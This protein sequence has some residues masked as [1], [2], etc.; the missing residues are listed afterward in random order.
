[1][2]TEILIKADP[3]HIFKHKVE[4]P[5]PAKGLLQ[6][7]N[8]VLLQGPEHLQLPKSRLFDLLIFCGRDSEMMRP[9]SPSLLAPSPIICY[10]P[11]LSL[12][13]LIATSS[14]VSCKERQTALIS[15]DLFLFHC[16]FMHSGQLSGLVLECAC[17]FI[18][19]KWISMAELHIIRH[20]GYQSI[21]TYTA[22]HG[23]SLLP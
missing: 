7:N 14:L 2:H 11:S 13:F 19:Y 12:N 5:P 8:V 6:L 17:N 4:F 3:F 15:A 20:S 9:S 21:N 22:T 16:A 18:L 23:A 10:S 1:M